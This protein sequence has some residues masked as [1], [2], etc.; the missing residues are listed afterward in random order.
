[1]SLIGALNTSS[2]A[3]LAQ[4]QGLQTVSNNIANVNTISY[5]R[6]ETLFQTLLYAQ[7]AGTNASERL[8][9]R[10]VDRRSVMAQGLIQSTGR[11]DDLAID[12]DGFFVVSRNFGSTATPDVFF[13]RDGALQ[14]RYV[15]VGNGAQESYYITADG[16]YL[17]GWAADENGEFS[18]SD[19]LSSLVPLRSFALDELEGTATTEALMAANIPSTTEIGESVTLQG[20]IYDTSYNSQTMSSVWTKVAANI[21]T[22]QAQVTNGTVT[23]PPT[24]PVVTFTGDGKVLTPQDPVQVSITWDDGTTSTIAVDLTDMEQYA[25]ETV[26]YRTAQ[27]GNETGRLYDESFDKNGV[28]WGSY[29]NGRNR[30]LYKVAVAQFVAPDSLEAV[31]GNLFR[32]TEGAGEMSIRDLEQEA[33]GTTILVGN[34]ESSN[35]DMADEFTRMMMVQKAYTMASTNF[36]TVDEMIETAVSMKR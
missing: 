21:W 11:A 12:G 30:A 32:A 13:T 6:E 9:V 10:A 7:R 25:D 31:S 36:R 26:I 33:Q 3:M 19:S 15:D 17:L 4:G 23:G 27:N 22:V 1:M 28:L 29:T 35:V 24:L 2:L 20:G 8:A 5:K 14:Q 34:L 16:K 18:T